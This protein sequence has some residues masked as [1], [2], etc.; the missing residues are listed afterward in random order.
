MQVLRHQQ[1][2]SA[3]GVTVQEFAHLAE[4]SFQVDADELSQQGFALFRGAEPGQ[5]QQ[6]GRRDG[7]QQS[8]NCCV[9]RD[10]APRALRVRDGMA[11][12]FRSAARS[13]HARR[14]LRRGPQR[15]ARSAW[16]CRFRA[17]RRS[18]TRRACRW[19]R[20]PMRGV[21]M[22]VPSLGRRR[23]SVAVRA[24]MHLRSAG[25]C[26]VTWTSGRCACIA[27]V[28]RRLR[29]ARQGGDEPIAA[30]WHGFYEAG[31]RGSSPRTVRRSLMA[32]FNT[33]SLTKR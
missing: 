26:P 19:S 6:P 27:R 17:R 16:S 29:Q 15:S 7:A 31:L 4:H 23:Q 18:R 9:S 10:T 14:R 32:P 12:R 5:L 20:G 13:D 8:W 22:Q 3:L 24:P 30:A 33:E 11:R 25:T 21:A 28:N 1:Q 2:R